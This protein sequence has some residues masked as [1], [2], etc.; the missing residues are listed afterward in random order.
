MS[1][2]EQ[3]KTCLKVI[4][5]RWVVA[6]KLEDAAKV[7]ESLALAEIRALSSKILHKK[8]KVE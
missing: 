8:S 4:D 3:T 2:V 7:S 1:D 6:K 5:M